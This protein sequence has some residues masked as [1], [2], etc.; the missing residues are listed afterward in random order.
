M[1][2][3]SVHHLAMLLYLLVLLV[4]PGS[5]AIVI[6]VR[7]N[8]TNTPDCLLASRPCLSLDYAI[9]AAKP[10]SADINVT[11]HDSHEINSSCSLQRVN[12]VSIIG[13]HG[14]SIYCNKLGTGLEIL[15]STS[16][17][18]SGIDWINCSIR[19]NTTARMELSNLVGKDFILKAYSALFFYKCTNVI[20]TG[21]TFT[22]TRGSGVSLYDILGDLLVENTLF[23]SHSVSEP[24][25]SCGLQLESNNTCSPQST[26]LYIEATYCGDFSVC[27]ETTFRNFSNTQYTIS[28]CTFTENNNTG[29]G[30]I[31]V[32]PDYIIMYRD[33]W[34]FGRGGGL[35]LALYSAIIF[36]I[37]VNISDTRFI[38][39]TAQYGGGMMVH[40]HPYYPQY[41]RLNIERC[42]FDGN[43]A[44]FNGGGLDL[45]AYLYYDA[46]DDSSASLDNIWS[47]TD[48]ILSSNTAKWGGGMAFHS[49]FTNVPFLS[50]SLERC[51]WTNN[52][53]HV[54]AAAA[55]FM[56]TIDQAMIGRYEPHVEINDGIFQYNQAV[57]KPFNT[58]LKHVSGVVYT[59]GIPL[60][61]YGNSQFLKNTAAALCVSDTGANFT[62]QAVFIGNVGFN[63]GALF[64]AGL[65]WLGLTYGVQ[66]EFINNTAFESGGAIYYEFPGAVA[67][68]TTKWCFIRYSEFGNVHDQLSQWNVNVSFHGNSALNAGSAVYISN[69][70]GCDWPNDT[71]T[72][73]PQHDNNKPSKFLFTGNQSNAADSI[74]MISSAPI[75]MTLLS[76]NKEISTNP[77]GFKYIRVMPGQ[78][79]DLTIM[80][81]DQQQQPVKTFLSIK[82]SLVNKYQQQK[83]F[84]DICLS[85]SAYDYGIV[86]NVRMLPSNIQLMNFAL[87]GPRYPRDEHFVLIFTTVESAAVTIPLMIGFTDC[88]PGY[89]YT[90]K[91]NTCECYD[92]DK[93]GNLFICY[94]DSMITAVPCLLNNYWYGHI[95]TFENRTVPIYHRC[96]PGRCSTDQSNTSCG[97]SEMYYTINRNYSCSNGLTGPLC[98]TCPQNL[99]LTYNAYGCSKC[100]IAQKLLL[101]LLIL[102]ECVFVVAAVVVFLKFNVK[103][104]T[105]SVYGLIYFYSVLPF[106]LPGNLP[107]P[108]EIAIL[109]IVDLASLEFD[110]LQFTRFCLF[111]EASAI[112]YEVLHFVYPVI[113]TLL[114]IL[115]IKIDQYCL[116]RFSFFSGFAAVQALCILLLMCY[117]AISVTSLRTVLPLIY[118]NAVPLEPDTTIPHHVFADPNVV[119]FDLHLHLPYWILAMLVLVVLVLPFAILMISAQWIMKIPCVSLAKIKPILDEYQNCFKDSCRWFAGVYLLARPLLFMITALAQTPATTSYLQQIFCISLLVMVATVQPY[120]KRFHNLLDTFLLS[121]LTVVSFTARTSTVQQI[122][123]LHPI[124]QFVIVSVLSLAPFLFMLLAFIV[125]SIRQCT[126]RYKESVKMRSVLNRA[127]TTRTAQHNEEESD[128]QQEENDN[129]LISTGLPDR[130]YE[131]ERAY[132]EGRLSNA[133][134]KNEGRVSGIRQYWRRFTSQ[135]HRH[136]G[137]RRVPTEDDPSLNNEILKTT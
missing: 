123:I 125:T 47:L 44:M 42:V 9:A 134:S 116:R 53:F 23:H 74:K 55:G 4:L 68:D 97:G 117:T 136:H 26:G 106:L 70:E 41:N 25:L 5:F 128:V 49:P 13:D 102:L 61:F 40:F 122:F 77:E 14:V 67:M 30:N 62:D 46:F 33:Q 83:F 36:N 18:V 98:S 133:T 65:S 121:D 91:T 20:I 7:N 80:V 90:E 38:M 110:W 21:C 45:H 104:S 35:G 28:N 59:E 37:S 63:G 126:V 81:Y 78:N 82:C 103:V 88:K 127:T 135:S 107:D 32:T 24:G 34:P 92:S 71:M 86:G 19:H 43:T 124:I 1:F 109:F 27:S 84:G 54:G 130:F 99:S 76:D 31:P 66:I 69:T 108:L 73:F 137:Y 8:G 2:S 3:L 58:S 12:R 15:N 22:S 111:D 72:L 11:V 87:N 114:V 51:N 129:L 79:L 60:H 131:H 6:D 115:L 112:H 56:R 96:L 94:R 50:L 93:D 29:A 119:Y 100:T 118:Q 64:M 95:Q 10:G 57:L 113:V 105:A 89:L 39:N 132:R 75:N 52:S 48:T 85:G 17:T 101:V 16:I 120:R